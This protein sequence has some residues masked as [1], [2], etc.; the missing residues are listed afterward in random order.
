MHR[1]KDLFLKLGT[2]WLRVGQQAKRGGSETAQVAF[3]LITAGGKG[4]ER[5][6]HTLLFSCWSSIWM[7]VSFALSSSLA[8]CRAAKAS[9]RSPRARLLVPFLDMVRRRG[10]VLAQAPPSRRC[11]CSSSPCPATSSHSPA[12]R[13]AEESREQAAV[14]AESMAGCHCPEHGWVSLPAARPGFSIFR[15]TSR[16]ATQKRFGGLA[17]ANSQHHTASPQL[18]FIQIRWVI[19]NEHF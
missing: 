1:P 2:G 7:S 5:K 16:C 18:P 17:H 6:T 13:E 3:I 4:E 10:G 19:V 15:R 8:A 14:T 12:G 11:G 9:G